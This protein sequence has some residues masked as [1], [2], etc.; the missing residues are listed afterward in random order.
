MDIGGDTCEALAVPFA[1]QKRVYQILPSVGD[2]KEFFQE[3]QPVLKFLHRIILSWK[4]PTQ[5][6][7][8]DSKLHTGPPKNPPH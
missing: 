2:G 3:V 1:C 5:I 8:F 4:G 6:V 7:Q